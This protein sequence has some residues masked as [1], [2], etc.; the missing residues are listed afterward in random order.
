MLNSAFTNDL[1]RHLAGRLRAETSGLEAQARLALSLATQR[2]PSATEVRVLTDTAARLRSEA[3][4]AE[5]QV[6]ERLALLT[7]NLNEF[8]FLD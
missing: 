3:G 5:E 8:V 7:L 1:A 4:L 2:E 6:L